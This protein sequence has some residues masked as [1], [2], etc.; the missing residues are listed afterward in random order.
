LGQALP[1]TVAFEYPTIETLTHY[2]A[3]DVLK[4]NVMTI[5]SVVE[6][7]NASR[8]DEAQKSLS[9]DELLSQ[10]DDELAAFSKLTDGD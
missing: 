8:G 9:E 6:D 7:S 3:N 1:S 2:L 4:L 5:G 10:L